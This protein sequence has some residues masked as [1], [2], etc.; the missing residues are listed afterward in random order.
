M[1]R[2]EA[3]RTLAFYA[4]SSPEARIASLV[5]TLFPKQKAFVTD[6]AKRKSALCSRRAGKTQGFSV[7]ACISAIDTVPGDVAYIGLT[8]G[9]AKRLM[10]RPLQKLNKDLSLGLEF[11]RA[12]LT[13]TDTKTGN[14]IFLFG[15]NTEDDTEKLRGLKLKKVQLDEAASFRK[16]LRY[17]IEEIIEPTLIDTDGV[18]EMGG[19]PSANPIENYFHD[20]TTGAVKGFSRHSWTILDNPFIPH[21]KRWLDDYRE[22]K[23]WSLEHPIY[24]REWLGH[25]TMDGDT[26]VYKYSKERNH[27]EDLPDHKL[28]HVLGCDLGF[29]DAFAIAV[30][31]YSED[32]RSVYVVDQFKKSGL[33]PSQMAEKIQE[34]RERYQPI[35]IVGDHGGLGKAICA[36]FQSRYHI[37]IKPAEKNQKRAY[38]ELMN[39]DLL[40]STLK[41]RHSSPLANEMQVLQWDADRPEK[42]DERTPNDLCD[43]ALYAWREAK[44]Y[45]GEDKRALPPI[46]TPEHWNRVAKALEEA[47]MEE[48]E[49][50]KNK[51]WWESM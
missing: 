49:G 15:A 44:H 16:H 41:I 38:I 25:W 48:F 4:S 32:T 13:A 3:L 45:L 11:N 28:M 29:D 43:A 47:D 17:L 18:L 24:Q 20:V 31:A 35:S 7:S 6:P 26:L 1:D 21:A 50:N 23:G 22:R 10:F 9:A 8:I 39:G 40:S 2:E 37:P 33:L 12:D 51:A 34:Y 14:T 19:T 27:Y 42:E 46:G 36:E 30:V 5:S